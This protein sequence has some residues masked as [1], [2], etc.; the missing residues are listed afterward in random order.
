MEL[1]RYHVC[2][3][4]GLTPGTNDATGNPVKCVRLSKHLMDGMY[5]NEDVKRE[6]SETR[7]LPDSKKVCPTGYIA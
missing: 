7:C 2:A 1:S 3:E 6:I 5:E 4:E